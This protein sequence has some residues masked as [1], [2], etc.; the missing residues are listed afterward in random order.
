MDGRE[1]RSRDCNATFIDL[2]ERVQE[3]RP[4]LCA[5]DETIRDHYGISHSLCKGSMSE[6]KAKIAGI[7]DPEINLMNQWRK[8][9]RQSSGMAAQ[10][11]YAGA[12][13]GGQDDVEAF[14]SLPDGSVNL[15]DS[16]NYPGITMTRSWRA[17]ECVWG[18]V[19]GGASTAGFSV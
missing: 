13:F 15:G 4:D 12:L 18:G 5:L 14:A 8:V 1:A 10:V 2:L 19:R 11:L 16:V 17:A 9:E 7:S 3:Q 6:A